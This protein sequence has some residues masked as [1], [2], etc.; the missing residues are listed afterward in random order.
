MTSIRL[1]AVVLLL[2]ACASRTS[3]VESSAAASAARGAPGTL[4]AL[5]RFEAEIASYEARDRSTP[6][7]PGG[8]VF[9]GSSSIRLW[10][11]LASDFPGLPVLNR[12]FGGS[13]LLEVNH[14]APRIVL[15]YR[16]RMIVLYAGDNEIAAGRS[17]R[18][19]AADYQAFVALVRR[20]LPSARIV[21]VSVKPSPSRWSLNDQV[22]EANR[23]VRAI[24]ATDS[25]QTFVD[26]FTPML[27][28][29]GRPRPELF[30]AD[31]LHMT[32][33]G[34][35]VWRGRL[36]PIVKSWSDLRFRR[37]E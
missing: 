27:N 10:T 36:A 18:W 12:G 34:Y 13:T 24:T 20:A 23:L 21:F 29:A 32:P 17:P 1:L 6:P 35:A 3:P 19:V 7:A 33:A 8:I 14:F 28:A 16:P 9:V 37:R 15:P 25:L 26:V 31:S 11:T 2:S 5:D 4:P 30:V 22:R